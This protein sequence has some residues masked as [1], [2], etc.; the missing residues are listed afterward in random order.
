MQIDPLNDALIKMYNAEQAG[1]YDVELH[2]ASKLLGN[3]L[4][5]MQKSGYI[6]EF[7]K[8]ENGRGGTYSVKLR[9]RINRCGTVKPRHSV[10][11]QEFE[12]WETRYLP[13]QDFGL[14]ILTTNSGVM[15]HYEAKDARIGGKLLAYVY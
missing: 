14:L 3:V 5:I 10:K 15:N 1:R 8:L 11:R 6:G 9:G 2:P 12:K 13:A 4:N 7:E